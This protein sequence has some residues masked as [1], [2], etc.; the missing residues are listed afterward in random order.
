MNTRRSRDALRRA[1]RRVGVPER[2]WLAGRL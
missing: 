1:L 2:S